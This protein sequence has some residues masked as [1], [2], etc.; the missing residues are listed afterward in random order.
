MLSFTK[1]KGK[2]LLVLKILK[3]SKFEVQKVGERDACI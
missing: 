2:H 1:A 3:L